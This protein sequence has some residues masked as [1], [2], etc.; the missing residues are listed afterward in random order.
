MYGS[1]SLVP[2]PAGI[3]ELRVIGG[4]M[5]NTTTGWSGFPGVNSRFH[6]RNNPSH[7]SIFVH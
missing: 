3:G 4:L 1:K 5:L 6:I 7:P 2:F